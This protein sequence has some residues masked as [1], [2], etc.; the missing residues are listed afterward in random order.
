LCKN[1]A[2][3]VPVEVDSDEEPNMKISKQESRRLV[4]GIAPRSK[5]IKKS[6]KSSKSKTAEEPTP[7]TVDQ[8]EK[9]P[10]AIQ[11]IFDKMTLR[12]Y[13]LPE[14]DILT[15]D[16]KSEIINPFLNIDMLFGGL[17]DGSNSGIV[18]VSETEWL[19]MNTQ[20][21]CFKWIHTLAGISFDN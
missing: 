17:F 13:L 9:F 7:K 20:E 15:M 14:L 2:I 10:I 21:R 18:H 3:N 8:F 4:P 1:S 5:S 12:F 6:E 16:F 19:I 11:V